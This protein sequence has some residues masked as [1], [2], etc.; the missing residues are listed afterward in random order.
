VEPLLT[1]DEA[2]AVLKLTKSQ[3]YEI[4]RSRSRCRQAVPIPFIKIGKRRLF[5]VSSL[6][7]WLQQLE[8]R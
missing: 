1:M 2:A 3:L 7:A 4:C 6:N 5:R 8:Q